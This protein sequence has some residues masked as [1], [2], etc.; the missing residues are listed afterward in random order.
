MRY[1]SISLVTAL[2]L[3]SLAI[4]PSAVSEHQEYCEG[5]LVQVGLGDATPL[6]TI[7]WVIVGDTPDAAWG[8]FESNGVPG[9][10]RGGFSGHGPLGAGDPCWT[11]DPAGPDFN[12][13]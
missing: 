6:A 11:D 10:Q 1:H 3:L 7:Y 12:F 2:V 5:T 4:A 9:L 13:Y 8:Y